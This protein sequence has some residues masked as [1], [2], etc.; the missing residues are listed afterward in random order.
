MSACAKG[1]MFDTV[2][3][4]YEAFPRYHLQPD[5][6]TLAALLTVCKACNYWEEALS[7]AE[8]FSTA[9]GIEMNTLACNTL[10]TTLGRAGRWQY[11][12][13]VSSSER[14]SC[15]TATILLLRAH[16]CSSSEVVLGGFLVTIRPFQGKIV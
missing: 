2:L 14:R 8:E 13:Q 15:S 1:A 4:L 16:K 10:I 12:L 3:E 6:F 11:A 5:I 9:H 7:F